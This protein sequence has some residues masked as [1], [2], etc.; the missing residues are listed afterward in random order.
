MCVY[1]FINILY[2]CAHTNFSSSLLPYY[3]SSLKIQKHKWCKLNL[4][5]QS[6]ECIYISLLFT[7]YCC[8][9]PN[10]LFLQ[11]FSNTKNYLPPEM[12]SFFTPGKVGMVWGV[13]V[14]CCCLDSGLSLYLEW[15]FCLFFVVCF[16]KKS[17]M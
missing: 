17:R 6:P 12:K 15:Q 2:I 8:N 14:W 7:D 16:L 9:C 11:N 3:R 4:S 13:R 10:P 1:I 5:V